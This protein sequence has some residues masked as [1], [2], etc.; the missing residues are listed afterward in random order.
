[1]TIAAVEVNRTRAASS[2]LDLENCS[3]S[4]KPKHASLSPSSVSAAQLIPAD[5]HAIIE[6]VRTCRRRARNILLPVDVLEG[7]RPMSSHSP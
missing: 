3:T 6:A 2:A 5:A 4:G 1:M 7:M